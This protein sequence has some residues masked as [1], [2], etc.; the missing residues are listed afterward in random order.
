MLVV[1]M[2]KIVFVV[3]LFDL[4]KWLVV[5]LIMWLGYGFVVIV[6]WYDWLERWSVLVL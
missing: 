6:V 2:L 5:L 4:M 3:V 1:I